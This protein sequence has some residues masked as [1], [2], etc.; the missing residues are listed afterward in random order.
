MRGPPA[1]H[2]ALSRKCNK[3]S[4]YQDVHALRG[5][6]IPLTVGSL[7]LELRVRRHACMYRTGV[8]GVGL[9]V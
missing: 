9:L 6:P 2:L 3:I 5:A 7:Y 1:C 4:L 8:P